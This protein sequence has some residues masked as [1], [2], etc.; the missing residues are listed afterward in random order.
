[1]GEKIIELI[2]G[3][4]VN[5]LGD[6]EL[7]IPAFVRNLAYIVLALISLAYTA[8][9]QMSVARNALNRMDTITKRISTIETEQQDMKSE[10][11]VMRVEFQNIF[12]SLS[13]IE[14]YVREMRQEQRR[15]R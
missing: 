10:Q 5:P 6:Q 12:K 8:G 15:N 13:S 4:K 14:T 7:N 11:K 9:N 2:G 1:M 3:K